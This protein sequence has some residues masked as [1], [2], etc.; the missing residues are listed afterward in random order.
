[1]IKKRF[2][3]LLGL[4]TS[5]KRQ[6]L[7]EDHHDNTDLAQHAKIQFNNDFKLEFQEKEKQQSIEQ[8]LSDRYDGDND[9]WEN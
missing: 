5:P 8:Q 7:I 3:F 4:A 1:M 2:F 9:E 6:E